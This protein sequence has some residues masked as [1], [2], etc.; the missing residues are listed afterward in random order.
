VASQ[1]AIASDA[2]PTASTT[3]IPRCSR[4]RRGVWPTALVNTAL[5]FVQQL[6]Q[7][8]PTG[9]AAAGFGGIARFDQRGRT[10]GLWLEYP[11]NKSF[12]DVLVDEHAFMAGQRRRRD[13]AR[14]GWPVRRRGAEQLDQFGG[15]GLG[16]QA[17]G[18]GAAARAVL[19]SAAE[20][21]PCPAEFGQF[22]AIQFPS[23]S[24]RVPA[25]DTR[26]AVMMSR[27]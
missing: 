12:T 6:R 10:A 14:W 20:I 7:F 17:H 18:I 16:Q 2:T 1:A 19:A 8:V 13:V 26:D 22:A 5:Q 3:R 27:R 23:P 4:I 9:G 24:N 11:K 25:T 21:P 15:L